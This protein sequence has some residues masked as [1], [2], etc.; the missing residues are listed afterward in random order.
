MVP[1]TQLGGVGSRMAI[2]RKLKT[3][4]EKQLK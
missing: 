1:A 3:L 4:T 2:G